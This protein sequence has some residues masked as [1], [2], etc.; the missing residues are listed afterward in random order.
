MAG[1]ATTEELAELTQLISQNPDL[2]ISIETFDRL[3]RNS[4]MNLQEKREADQAYHRHLSRM[5][6]QGIELHET[7]AHSGYSAKEV[8]PSMRFRRM[9]SFSLAAAVVLLVVASWWIFR[10]AAK[11]G[12]SADKPDAMVKSEVS[13][14]NGSKTHI[15]LPDGSNVWLNSGSKLNYNNQEFGQ[16]LREVELI[17]EG[18]FDVV[19]NPKKPFIIHTAS[20]DVKVLGTQFNVKSYPGDK[21]TETSLIRGSVEVMVRKRPNEKY[22]LKPNEKI[23]VLNEEDKIAPRPATIRKK[24]SLEPIIAIQQLTYKEGDSVAVETAWAFN[25]LQFLD[26]PMIDVAH[27]MERWYDVKFEF[28]N[29]N[30]EDMRVKGTFITETLP[31][32]MEALAYAYRLKYEIA[33]KT[34]IIY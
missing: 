24:A 23:V 21:T 12:D 16:V 34:V 29:R 14:K 4:P 20:I 9:R 13:T 7:E 3:W 6:E 31:E 26:E 2:H 15:Q 1:E 18:F 17:G 8:V 22:I 11:A 28:R 25:K 33:G 5:R 32:A 30:I 10:P 27:K 19:K